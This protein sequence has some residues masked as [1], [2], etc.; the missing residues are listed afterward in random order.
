M[1]MMH[2]KTCQ[3]SCKIPDVEYSI[4]LFFMSIRK[5]ILQKK[6]GPAIWTTESFKDFAYTPKLSQQFLKFTAR[7]T[8]S[9]KTVSVCKTTY[10][11]NMG[12]LGFLW[13]L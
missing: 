4:S 10:I 11:W 6:N 3:K 7:Y 1:M 13:D 9:G 8:K 2:C 12:Q 5:I